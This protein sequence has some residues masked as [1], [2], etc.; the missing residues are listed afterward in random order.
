MPYP[1]NK[2]QIKRFWTIGNEP[3]VKR[4]GMS[5]KDHRCFTGLFNCR[6]S[7]CRRSSTDEG[8]SNRRVH[9]P[10]AGSSTSPRPSRWSEKGRL[11]RGEKSCLKNDASEKR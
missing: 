2:G 10:Y 9:A 1:M 5:K 7:A 3:E 6:F 11:Y 4:A 8:L